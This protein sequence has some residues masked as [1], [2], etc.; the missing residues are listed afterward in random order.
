MVGTI[1]LLQL[2]QRATEFYQG[3]LLVAGVGL[4]LVATDFPK[5][6]E[7]LPD[8]HQPLSL[9]LD[10]ALRQ[11]VRAERIVMPNFTLHQTFDQRLYD[12][13]YATQLVH[14]LQAVMPFVVA[15]KPQPILV[16]GS[17][18]TME[19]DYVASYLAHYD[20]TVLA[21]HEEWKRTMDDLRIAAYKKCETESALQQFKRLMEVTA[22]RHTIVV[23]C[24]ELSLLLPE[25]GL[26]DH[27]N[28]IDT[29]QCQ[30]QQ[31]LG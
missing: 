25:L 12:S 22:V 24:T 10:V 31:A 6:N 7:N 23:A 20:L 26:D 4:E 1:G 27:K 11:F 14:P 15:K 3:R 30:I 29:A 2:G 28:I 16:A 21:P 8:R 13:S 19:S 9:L 18:Y 5:I 17:R